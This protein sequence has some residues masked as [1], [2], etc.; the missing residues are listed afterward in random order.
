MS[1]FFGDLFVPSLAPD[2]ARAFLLLLITF[3]GVIFTCSKLIAII[4]E[5]LLSSAIRLRHGSYLE[6][7]TKAAKSC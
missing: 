1:L 7:V 2:A 6:F 5:G 4:K 3:F